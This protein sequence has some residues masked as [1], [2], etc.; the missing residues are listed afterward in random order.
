MFKTYIVSCVLASLLFSWSQ[1]RGH[2]L[3]A[4]GGEREGRSSSNSGVSTG[5]GRIYHK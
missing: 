3:F 1:F 5:S 4:D 2:S